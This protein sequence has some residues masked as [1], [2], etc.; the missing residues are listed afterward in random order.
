MRLCYPGVECGEVV[1]DTPLEEGE[2]RPRVSIVSR[3]VGGRAAFS[4]PAGW[5]L[6]GAPETVCLPAADW[7][8]PFPVCRGQSTIF[9]NTTAYGLIEFC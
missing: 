4:C 2:R 5:A 6:R 1:H 3:G 9:L 8:K 7:A